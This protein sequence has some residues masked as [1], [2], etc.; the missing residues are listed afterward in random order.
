MERQRVVRKDTIL[1]LRKTEKYRKARNI[2]VCIIYCSSN[3]WG[4]VGVIFSILAYK[5]IC[6]R[7]FYT[8]KFQ[9]AFKRT[10]LVRCTFEHNRGA[11]GPTHMQQFYILVY[12]L[13][14]FDKAVH[15]YKTR[16]PNYQ[17]R[18][19]RNTKLIWPVIFI[20]KV[21][22]D[23]VHGHKFQFKINICKL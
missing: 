18:I 19:Y 7:I 8:H 13:N 16:K 9:E 5:Y 11:L 23:F 14:P 20:L 22:Q 2:S 4:W 3:W 10:G 15:S 1:P 17:N 12:R 21:W 6:V